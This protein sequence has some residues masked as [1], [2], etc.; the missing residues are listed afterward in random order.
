MIENVF[1]LN[2][3]LMSLEQSQHTQGFYH[4][5]D[6][7]EHKTE[8]A[9]KRYEIDGLEALVDLERISKETQ[10]YISADLATLCTKLPLNALKKRWTSLNEHFQRALRTSNSFALLPNFPI[11][12]GMI[13]EVSRTL[14]VSFKRFI[15]CGVLCANTSSDAYK[16]TTDFVVQKTH[17]IVK[18]GPCKDLYRLGVD[19]DIMQQDVCTGHN[20]ELNGESIEL[21]KYID[22][23]FQEPSDIGF[24]SRRL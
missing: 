18:Q 14:S 12:A 3:I 9:A 11:V 24:H 17:C 10:G 13:S 16:T 23:N 20:N 22:R 4:L 5:D 2:A 8:K 15:S 21:I 1:Q 7:I 19:S 6:K